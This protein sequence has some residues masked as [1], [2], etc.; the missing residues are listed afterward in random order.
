MTE[1]KTKLGAYG[2]GTAPYMQLLAGISSLSQ[3]IIA[4]FPGLASVA[5][6]ASVG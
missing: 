3:A 1:R 4:M 5:T 6:N 2:H